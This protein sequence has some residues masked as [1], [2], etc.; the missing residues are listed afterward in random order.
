[1]RTFILQLVLAIGIGSM[2]YAQQENT[3]PTNYQ[4]RL[5]E[6]IKT[7]E[8]HAALEAEEAAREKARRIKQLSEADEQRARDISTVN[9]EAREAVDAIV[10]DSELQKL[11][12][13]TENIDLPPL[14][15]FLDAAYE[16][17]TIKRQ[18]AAMDEKM[19]AYTIVKRQWLNYFR[20]NGSYSYGVFSALTDQSNIDTPLFQAW[21]GRAQHTYNLGAGFSISLGDLFTRKQQLKVQ[22]A[23]MRQ[24][25]YEYDEVVETRKLKILDAYNKVVEQLATIKA[26]AESAAMYNAQMKISENEFINGQITL[27][28]LS[29]ER[30]RRTGALVTFQECKVQLHNAITLLELLTNV[31]VLDQSNK[32]TNTTT[33][34]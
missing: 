25:Q 9:E 15:V 22:K 2:V 17:A 28:S 16:N 6:L 31:K 11:L 5:Q 18:E 33:H 20:V 21:S 1:M 30:A 12:D 14:S 29:L 10:V 13:Q 27:I 24:A 34:N 32:K 23:I 7:E 26:K 19:A 4:Q 3:S 8:E